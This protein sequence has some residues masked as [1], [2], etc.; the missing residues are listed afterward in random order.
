MLVENHL[1]QNN[2]RHLRYTVKT[3]LLI[4]QNQIVLFL[5]QTVKHNHSQQGYRL[6]LLRT[7]R[8]ML[9]APVTTTSHSDTSSVLVA[10]QRE[11][12]VMPCLSINKPSVRTYYMQQF[13]IDSSG[14]IKTK[15]RYSFC[16]QRSHYLKKVD[17]QIINFNAK[18]NKVNAKKKKDA[19]C[20]Q[21]AEG[22]LNSDCRGGWRVQ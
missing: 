5:F 7:H 9:S 16:P 8:I 15:G 11:L 19:P 20:H 1:K 4:T 12:W 17:R 22:A 3:G 21:R 10:K 14:G 2:E 6:H 18:Q 13:L